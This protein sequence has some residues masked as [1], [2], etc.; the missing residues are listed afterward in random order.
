MDI[1]FFNDPLV[2][3]E[4]MLISGQED[5]SEL[6]S[7]KMLAHMIEVFLLITCTWYVHSILE[8]RTSLEEDLAD[9]EEIPFLKPTV[10]C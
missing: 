10:K 6:L 7:N 4:Q 2:G 1:C 9:Q 5:K 3:G 8:A